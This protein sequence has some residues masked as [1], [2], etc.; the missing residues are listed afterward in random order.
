MIE[1]YKEFISINESR[2]ALKVKCVDA[3]NKVKSKYYFKSGDDKTYAL[4]EISFAVEKHGTNVIKVWGGYNGQNDWSD[5]F[6]A[7]KELFK[8]LNENGIR[9]WVIDIKN[10]CPDDVFDA[11]IGVEFA[12]TKKDD[13][14]E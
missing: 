2:D 8:K 11:R 9:A 6:D 13:E 12:D 3:F 7:L 14:E 4:R 5:Y 10:D 1:G